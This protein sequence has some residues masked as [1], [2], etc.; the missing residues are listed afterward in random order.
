MRVLK[1]FMLAIVFAVSI[2]M[3]ASQDVKAEITNY[4]NGLSSWGFPVLPGIGSNI[5]ADVNVYWVDS[6]DG[7]K[8]DGAGGGSAEQPFATIN[9]AIGQCVANQGDVILGKPGHTERVT[10]AAGLA[11]DVAGITIIGIGNGASRP[12]I[13]FTT[14][15]TADMD[16]DAANITM[17]N[18]LF[19]AR[20]AALAAPIDINAADFFLF[21]CE[22]RDISSTSVSADGVGGV[23]T[24]WIQ[25]DANADR[26]LVDGLR[27]I[28][29][30]TPVGAEATK[31]VSCVNLVGGDDIIIK[32][33]DIYGNF[34]GAPVFGTT[35]P[36]VRLKVQNGITWNNHATDSAVTVRVD[37]TGFIGPDLK[38]A[39]Q[40]DADNVTEAFAGAS[41]YFMPPLKVVNTEGEQATDSAITFT[42]N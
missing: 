19:E 17:V 23:A 8:A 4:P 10:E 1:R 34:A 6:T 22:F 21:N 2:G 30:Q 18:F 37:S 12:T 7:N 24:D 38:A 25:T 16:V 3:V 20:V 40:D 29:T 41:M 5:F 42:Q 13:E 36:Q 39:L 28:G 35:T 31:P 32:N 27:H 9:F 15:T 26:L 14:A 33:F 11:L